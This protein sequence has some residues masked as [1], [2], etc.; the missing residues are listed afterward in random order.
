M[1]EKQKL[2]KQYLQLRSNLNDDLLRKNEDR[3]LEVLKSSDIKLNGKKVSCYM[4]VKNEMGTKKLIKLLIAEGNKVFLPKMITCKKKLTFFEVKSFNDLSRNEIG[5]LEPKE[6]GK[7]GPTELDYI[8]MPCVCFD[9]KGFRV[10]MGLSLIH[11]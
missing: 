11:I 6:S 5:I 9:E 10:G 4:S 7:I 1:T 8:F 3:V 2:R